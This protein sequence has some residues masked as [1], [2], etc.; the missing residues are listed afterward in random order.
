MLDR[1]LNFLEKVYENY[2]K[3]LGI[4]IQSLND[5]LKKFLG[6]FEKKKRELF[7]GILGADFWEYVFEKSERYFGENLKTFCG[8]WKK[9]S[10]KVLA[11]FS[12]ILLKV[13]K[14]LNDIL[15]KM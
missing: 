14:D 2:G 9:I 10:N 12:E 13:C 4:S 6:H 3:I 11:V 15:W 5:I 8:N 7:S 1:L